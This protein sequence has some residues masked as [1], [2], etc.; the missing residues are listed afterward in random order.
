[1]RRKTKKPRVLLSACLLGQRLRYDGTHARDA[2]LANVLGRHVEWV[3][4][5]PETECGF[6]VPREPMR[7][8]GDPASPR[9]VTVGSNQDQ[10]ENIRRWAEKKFRDL[11]DAGLCGILLKSGSPCCGLSGVKVF[12]YNG[13]SPRSC[14]TG[15]FARAAMRRFPLIPAADEERMKDPTAR[16]AFIERL[17][18][19][20]RW[21]D[22]TGNGPTLDGL[23]EFHEA[24]ELL[25]YAHDPKSVAS[26]ERLIRGAARMNRLKL[27]ERYGSTMMSALG[28][29]PSTAKNARALKMVFQRLGGGVSKEVGAHL[30]SV[31]EDYRAGLVPFLVP[32]A[33]MRHY[34]ERADDHELRRQFFLNPYPQ[35]LGLRA[36]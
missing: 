29:A 18:A 6:S 12:G 15:I 21:R 24:H 13:A 1:M 9:V 30:L 19:A 31:I 2:Y 22:F 11:E 36:R 33:L 27:L 32:L 4:I 7:L 34:V 3:P 16:E 25:I 17:Y 10:T 35:E 23:T 28:V 5:C 20:M 26:M 14:G 8:R